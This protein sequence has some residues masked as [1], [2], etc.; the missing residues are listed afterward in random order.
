MCI[1]KKDKNPAGDLIQKLVWECRSSVKEKVR[2]KLE[3]L[4]NRDR[5]MRRINEKGGQ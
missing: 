5:W 4:S 1:D 3:T 2:K